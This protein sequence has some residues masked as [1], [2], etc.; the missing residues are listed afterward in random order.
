MKVY[1][2][3]FKRDR[4]PTR[5][6]H[7]NRG[8]YMYIELSFLCNGKEVKVLV[9]PILNSEKKLINWLEE[10]SSIACISIHPSVKQ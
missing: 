7:S 2:W 4:I 1:T 6:L 8:A 9:A 3:L 10:I 5:K